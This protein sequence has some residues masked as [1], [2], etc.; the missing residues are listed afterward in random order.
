MQTC[1][2]CGAA[3][4]EGARFC[5]AC[6][7]E[8]VAPPVGREQRKTVTVLFCDVTGSTALGER[9]DPESLRHV[10]ARYFDTAREA[11]ERHGGTVEKFIGDAVMA[12]FGVPVVHEDDALRCV[13]AAVE[14]RDAL[15]PLNGELAR[16]YGT[17]L[18][19]RIGVTTGEVVTGTEERLATGDAVNVAARLEQ[20][21]A[22]GEILIGDA[23]LLLVREAVEVEAIDPLELRGKAEAVSAYRL[24]SV[25]AGVGTVTRNLEAPMVGRGDEL[26]VL[27]RA[28]GRATHER[29]CHLFTVLGPAGVGKSRLAAEFLGSLGDTAVLRGRCLPY[30]EGITYWP[31]VEVLKQILGADPAALDRYALDSRATVALRS[32]L[33][34]ESAH[35]SAEEIAWAVRKLLEAVAEERPLVCV[36]DDVHWGE[37]TFLDLVE[38]I[39]DLSRGAPI[40]LLCMGRPELLDR[41]SGWGGGKLNATAV[42]LEPLSAQETDTLIEE[43]L[44]DKTVEGGLRARISEAAEGNPLFV[45]EM[46]AMLRDSPSGEVV[47]PPTIQALLAARLDQLDPAERGV[48]ERGSVEG[49]VF[50]R[51][52]VEALAPDDAS[53]GGR[54]TSLV[55]KELVRPDRTQIPGDD[56][57]RFRH[58]LIRDAAYDGLPKAARAELHE[59]FTV[60]LEEFGA[61]LVELDEILGY[62]LEQAYRYRTALG[63]LDAAGRALGERA[64][65]RLAAVGLLAHARN[66]QNAAI[67]LLE[68]ARALL[69]AEPVDV[70]LGLSLAGALFD[71]GRLGDAV[72]CASSVAAEAAAVGDEVGEWAARLEA[73]RLA[74]NVDP[75]ITAERILELVASARPIL[76]RC[77]DDRALA[78]VALAEIWAQNSLCQGA[79]TAD[80]ARRL[81]EIARRTGDRDREV[82]G[83]TWLGL[84]AFHGPMP[85]AEAL[86]FL[87]DEPEL[88]FVIPFRAS[89]RGGLLAML[90]RFDEARVLVAAE[91]RRFLE[92]GAVVDAAL[93]ECNSGA[94]ELLAGD[95][96]AA[97]RSLRDGCDRLGSVGE[98]GYLSTFI[99]LLG[100]VLYLL[101]RLDEAN[102]CASRGEA[103]GATDD[104]VTQMLWRQLRGKV[105][106]RRSDLAAGEALTREAVVLGEQ[107]DALQHRADATLD[108]AEVLQLAGQYELAA[109]ELR[110]ALDL[111]ERKGNLV[112]AARVRER[113]AALTL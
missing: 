72:A 94:I 77:A 55:R 79:E 70:H 7:A 52:A 92:L 58:L 91:R 54:L 34:D 47:V 85:V 90:G 103:L 41:R 29:S 49:R 93:V 75:S 36:L 71:G 69:P 63:P 21:A 4:R 30:G 35:A 106:A 2:T 23:T 12:V 86:R 57:F 43:L 24:L 3:N 28:W 9:L 101:G 110:R 42:L 1:P 46:V 74:S 111:Y 16:D 27:R 33:G 50:H 10:L 65:T 31:V 18:A 68:R 15:G 81:V 39:A 64:S 37:E 107:T 98:Q 97:E 56:A 11:V 38:H 105:L 44:S 95:L 96:P 61:D 99:A 113:L 32:V 53:A 60:W 83:L 62:H 17:T 102:D 59:R 45:E 66:D 88:D 108:L 26:D 19:L 82:T 25:R 80:A 87:E 5:D 14:I 6:G 51:G 104:V 112:M 20:A 89:L 67:A 22:S 76:E 100:Q 73:A 8:L 48:L 40:L 13:R 109:G 84:T 78:V